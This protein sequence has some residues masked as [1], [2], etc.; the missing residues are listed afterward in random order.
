[1]VDS[2]ADRQ[3]QV[4]TRTRRGDLREKGPLDC[5]KVDPVAGAVRRPPCPL[6]PLAGAL[7]KR[8]RQTQVGLEQQV[9]EKPA[10]E[11]L[12]LRHICTDRLRRSMLCNSASGP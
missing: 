5:Y 7:G 9:V 8:G 1:M 12:L 10:C 11:S 6:G 2:A 4:V 3:R